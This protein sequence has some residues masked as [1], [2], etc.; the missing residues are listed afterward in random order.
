MRPLAVGAALVVAGTI[1]IG[2]AL[3]ALVLIAAGGAATS[4]APV[5]KVA[6]SAQALADIPPNLL[7]MFVDEA[8]RCDGLPW[9]VL[10]A[11]SRVESD[12]GRAGGSS[13]G[14]DGVDAPPI[15]GVALDGTN[16]TERTVDTDGGRWDR[17]TM[18]D[19]AVGPFQFTP[20]AWRIF[21]SD[22]SGD[23][24]ADPNNFNDALPAMRRR[25]CPE[26]HIVDVAAAVGAYND[27]D[28]YLAAVLE[29][30]HRYTAPK[31]STTNAHY[32]LPVA[33]EMV[34][35]TALV[36]PHHDY[37]AWDLGVPV[38]TPVFAVTDGTVV[39]ATTAGVYPTDP[40]RCGSTVVIA[41]GDG[42]DYVYCHLSKVTV[43]SG[44]QLDA[45]TLIGL[46]GGRPGAVGAGNTTGPHV[47]LGVRV[48]GASVCPQPLLL[49]IERGRS[50]VPSAA[51]S[52]GCVA[53]EPL[54]DW[55]RWLT[56]H[57]LDSAATP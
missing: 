3:L 36:Q 26:G 33:P 45:G 5:A 6:P 1:A 34:D 56:D 15:I 23:G 24:V 10:A 7:P 11:I 28:T 53:G 31:P 51:P 20:S 19:H 35:E 44:Q 49:A 37:P 17:D 54:T 50:I 18:W 14:A 25:L 57:Q 4:V 8:T 2:L 40:N 42:A 38:G 21:G 55:P 39:T 47:H 16:G 12:H 41:G 32:G 13:I 29:W 30:S 52:N 22:A 27:S 9:T 48:D 43:T 46:S